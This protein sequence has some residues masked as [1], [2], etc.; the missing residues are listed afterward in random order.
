MPTSY[1]APTTELEAVNEILAAI[2]ETPVSTLS[3]SLPI[4]ASM[5]LTRLRSRSR[6]LQMQGWSFNTDDEY[7]LAVDGDGK[8]PVP[9]SALR[10]DPVN[11][12]DYVVRGSFLY[13]R[14]EHTYVIDEAVDCDVIWM[15]PWDDIPEYARQYLFIGTAR[16][17]QDRM[18]G[19]ESLHQYTAEDERIAWGVFLECEAQNADLNVLTDSY[20]VNRVIRRRPR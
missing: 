18:L 11:T 13:D 16:T 3:G 5:A 12:N 6:G 10:V 4:D 15:L 20:S 14:I 9:G 19:D 2:G 8:V 1:L 7:T 17:F